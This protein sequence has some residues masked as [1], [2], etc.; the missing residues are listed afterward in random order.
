MSQKDEELARCRAELFTEL[1]ELGVVKLEIE[2]SGGGDS[3]QVDNISAFLEM[4]VEGSVPHNVDELYAAAVDP[5]QIPIR[6]ANKLLNISNE[7]LSQKYEQLAYD[8]LDNAGVSDWRNNEG[9]GGTLHVFVKPGQHDNET[10]EAGYIHADHHYYT[11]E[12]TYE[13]YSL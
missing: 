1:E 4:P 5:S 3:G 13:T 11:Q 6:V 7:R 12:A 10:Y 8:L 2:Y 9:G